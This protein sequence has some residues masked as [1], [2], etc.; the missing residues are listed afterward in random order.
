MAT[1][2]MAPVHLEH[3]RVAAALTPPVAGSNIHSSQ[4]QRDRVLAQYLAND[5]YT[6][7]DPALSRESFHNAPSVPSSHHSQHEQ[8]MD[9][10][11]KTLLRGIKFEVS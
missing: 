8:V 9:W 4:A 5:H 3:M 11:Q 6:V 10:E 2:H 7:Q 1:A